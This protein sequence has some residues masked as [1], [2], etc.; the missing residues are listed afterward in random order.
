ML[1]LARAEGWPVE[2]YERV[3]HP[4]QREMLAVV[5]DLVGLRPEQVPIGVDG[6]S[7]PVFGAPL[8]AMALAYARF[9]VAEVG[10][11]A[12][13]A[14]MAR[15]R[16]MLALRATEATSASTASGAHGGIVAKG[17]AGRVGNA[18]GGSWRSR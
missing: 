4:V 10:G 9:A 8:A 12:R 7:V 2:G 15:I 6:C 14:A 11:D 13:G 18:R 5:A 3:D 17:G 1:A 16:A